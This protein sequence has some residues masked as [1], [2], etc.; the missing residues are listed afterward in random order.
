M[1]HAT[2]P[3]ETDLRTHASATPAVVE[4][5]RI[6]NLAFQLGL[7]FTAKHRNTEIFHADS[8]VIYHD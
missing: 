5:I 1:S 6:Y 8:S 3:G 7:A 4:N 2:F